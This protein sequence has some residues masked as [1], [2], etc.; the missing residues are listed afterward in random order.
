MKTVLEISNISLVRNGQ[1]V[2]REISFSLGEGESA[3]LAGPNGAGKSS[4]LW[5]ILGL[6]HAKG[7]ISK[8]AAT[9][10]VFQN[11][12][13]QLFMPSLLDDLMLPLLCAGRNKEQAR[14]AALDGLRRF[15][16]DALANRPASELSLGQRKRASLALALVRSPELLLLDE[17][18]AELD[19]RASR[20]LASALQSSSAARL[21]ASHDLLFLR[22]TCTRLIIID[23]GRIQADGL[24]GPLLDDHSL[25]ERHGLS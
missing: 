24:A 25:L 3:G 16:I 13:D 15:E 12:E 18:T 2:L 10:A 7:S 22:R 4:L 19:P 21:V 20:L 6:L 23:Q 5:C 17:P 14:A 9:S 1:P 8:P 11:P